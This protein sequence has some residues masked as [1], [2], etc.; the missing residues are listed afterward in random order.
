MNKIELI[1]DIN[2]Y[3]TR[4]DNNMISIKAYEYVIILDNNSNVKRT[5][6]GP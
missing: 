5:E 2:R 6:V 1:W 3:L 4:F